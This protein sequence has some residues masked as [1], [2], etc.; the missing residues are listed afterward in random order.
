VA[1]SARLLNGYTPK[2]YRGFES[3]PLRHFHYPLIIR[4]LMFL[5][6]PESAELYQK[7]YQNL[8]VFRGVYR[9][10]RRSV[11]RGSDA[12][13]RVSATST[14]STLPSSDKSYAHKLRKLSACA[15][16]GV[17]ID[18]RWVKD[19]VQAGHVARY[20]LAREIFLIA[21]ALLRASPSGQKRF[22]EGVASGEI[23]G[24]FNFTP[25]WPVEYYEFLVKVAGPKRLGKFDLA[26]AV[27][28]R[29]HFPV[30]QVGSKAGNG[31]IHIRRVKDSYDQDYVE[32]GP[33]A[34]Y[35][36]IVSRVD[37]YGL[38]QAVKDFKAWAERSGYFDLKNLGGRPPATLLHLAYFRFTK[39]PVRPKSHGSLF[40]SAVM[41]AEGAKGRAQVTDFGVMLFE[42]GLIKSGVSA[43]AWSEGVARIGNIVMP[44]AALIA[45]HYLPAKK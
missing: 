31:A 26:P 3:H 7:L 18:F 34:Y 12:S 24:C 33:D 9:C 45:S 4:G 35:E 16:D 20:E 42:S 30:A 1:E 41:A 40:A 39:G 22:R 15:A 25:G 32:H 36:L 17:D 8:S 11:L 5:G 6:G 2:G 37:Q 29:D 10:L 13:H 19:A 27:E 38:V 21:D 23:Y 43:A 14:R 28:L 44:A